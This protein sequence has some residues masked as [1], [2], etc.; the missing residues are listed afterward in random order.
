MLLGY[1]RFLLFAKAFMRTTDF[2]FELPNNLIAQRPLE[3]RSDSRLMVLDRSSKE[4]LHKK[5]I[6][7]VD[8]LDENDVLVFN[9][10][11]VIPARIYGFVGESRVE[12]LLLRKVRDFEWL[13]MCKPGKK[14]KVGSLV[15]FGSDVKATVLEVIEDGSRI[16]KFNCEDQKIYSIGEAPLPPYIKEKSDMERYQ[17]VYAKEEGSV[18]APTAGLHFTDEVL[19]KLKEKGVDQHYVTLHVGRGTFMPV[20]SDSVGDHQMHSERYEVS[21]EVAETL[22][23]L[24]SEGKRMV[25]V[26]TTSVRTLESA[27]KDGGLNS[28]SGETDIFI[29]PGYEFKFVD[30]L[31]TNFHL[32]KSTLIMLVSA[33]AGRDFVLEAYRKAVEE[34]YRFYSFGDSMLIQ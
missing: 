9:Q 31:I 15:D 34:E 19:T 16:L 28:G 10:S 21:D 5:F 25:A 14:F 32:P 23:K 20:K 24:K 18:A 13:V 30:K 6:D 27:T 26:G 17:T 22:N 11:K 7:I 29:T 8:L 33:L 2:D 3:N 1:V 12:I 4:V